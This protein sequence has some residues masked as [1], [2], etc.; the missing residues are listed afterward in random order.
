MGRVS[1][2]KMKRV[3]GMDGGDAGTTMEMYLIPQSCAL[4]NG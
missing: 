1:L 4:K 2:Y 3:M